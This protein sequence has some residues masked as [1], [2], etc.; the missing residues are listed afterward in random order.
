MFY[1]L[2]M[3][4]LQAE[5]EHLKCPW[6]NCSE[7]A[8]R[9]ARLYILKEVL[10]QRAGSLNVK[11]LLFKEN[12]VSQVKGFSAFLCT[13]RCKS[14]DSLKSFFGM[15][16][17]Y[18]WLESC[19]FTSWNCSGLTVGSGYSLMVGKW[20]V[21]FPSRVP[22]GHTGSCQ[23]AAITDNCDILCLLI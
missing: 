12:Q 22:S 16:L 7:E 11:K 10:Q 18:L 6:E 2:W 23:R 9:G 19:V 14:L 1:S 3:F 21:F 17:S 5:R 8:R 20:Q 13:G 15:H 4:G